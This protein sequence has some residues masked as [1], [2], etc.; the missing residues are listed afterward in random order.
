MIDGWGVI[1]GSPI[2]KST[3]AIYV[4]KFDKLLFKRLIIR[5]KS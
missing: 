1:V 2:G 5:E 3:S 4:K